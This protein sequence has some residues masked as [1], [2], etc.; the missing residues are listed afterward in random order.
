LR[1]IKVA[2]EIR[3]TETINQAVMAGM[4]LSFLS[5]TPSVRSYGA[6]TLRVLDVQDSR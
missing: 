5:R 3:S 6:G 2:M 1:D 4:G